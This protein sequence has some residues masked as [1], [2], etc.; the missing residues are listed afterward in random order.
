MNETRQLLQD[1]VTRLFGDTV[2]KDLI[3]EV[4]RGS[5]PSEL[6][7]A[8]EQAGLTQPYLLEEGNSE[9]GWLGAFEILRAG[10]RYSVPLPLAETIVAGWLLHRA[11]IEVPAG[12][13]T[14]VT[15][16]LAD[17][18]I[19]GDKVSVLLERVPW[20]RHCSHVV[21]IV[22]S[23]GRAAVVRIDVGGATITEGCNVALEPRDDMQVLHADSIVAKAATLPADVTLLYGAM[24]RSA[25]MAGALEA[26]LDMSVQYA[27]ER[28]QFGRP[29][30]QFQAI[31]QEL[32]K[33][34]GYTAEAV[35]AAEVACR[36]ASET[37][38][39]VQGVIGATRDPSFEI[40]CAKVVVG[41]AAELAPRIAHQVHGA[42]GFTYEH[43]LHF[44][45]RRLWSWRA[46]LGTSG[47]WARRLG[48]YALQVGTDD[49]W[50]RI[51]AR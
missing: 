38:T 23:G 46:E 33:L 31:Q 4:E 22:P 14:F 20:G 41:E 26:L 49:L 44:A 28:I 47:Y 29:I 27:G 5:W 1:T 34:A 17:S 32:A 45:S 12:P 25:Q 51:T 6:W 24:A 11:G 10:G 50:P 9:A 19:H 35:A 43:A 8:V 42:I 2:G 36:A 3:A 37:G 18:V 30:G 40:A 13:L 39:S 16:P 21:A 7:A 48:K 15:T